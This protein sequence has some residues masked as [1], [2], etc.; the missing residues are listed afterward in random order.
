LSDEEFIS[1]HTGLKVPSSKTE[2]MRNFPYWTL[3]DDYGENKRRLGEYQNKDWYKEGYV[4]SPYDQGSCGGCWAFSAASAV[5][6]LSKIAGVVD[7]L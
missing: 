3:A 6:S 2:K 5:E 4:T 7:E 1:K